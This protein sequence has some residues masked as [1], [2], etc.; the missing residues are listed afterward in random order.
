MLLLTFLQEPDLGV[1]GTG[2]EGYYVPPTKG[3]SQSQ[4]WVNNSQ[5]PG[6]HVIAGSFE[7]AMRVRNSNSRV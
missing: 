5:L 1:G 6:D 4:V 3:T 7:T 2:E